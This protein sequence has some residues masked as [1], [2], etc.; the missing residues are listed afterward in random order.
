M[1]AGDLAMQ[2]K[3]HLSGDVENVE[4]EPRFEITVED[5]PH[6]VDRLGAKIGAGDEISLA[7]LGQAD[8][9]R[10]A[11]KGSLPLANSEW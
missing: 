4:I 9:A 8:A 3:R 10:L 5:V 2:L 6:L 1:V 7:D 11:L